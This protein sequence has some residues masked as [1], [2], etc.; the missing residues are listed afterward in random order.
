MST[1]IEKV[2]KQLSE[3][4]TIDLE[5]ENFICKDWRMY[6]NLFNP[7]NFEN[8]E[9]PPAWY[10]A[11]SVY[12]FDENPAS[13]ENIEIFSYE[14]IQNFQSLVTLIE[15]A[16][17]VENRLLSAIVHHTFGNGGAYAEAKFYQYA[18]RTIELLHHVDFTK[19][20][21]I[22][23]NL[24]LRTIEFG[25]EEFELILHFNCSWKAEH[26]LIIYLVNNEI[27]SIE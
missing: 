12:T 25:S 21:F 16:E 1:F 17:V 23:R 19:E 2:K 4:I 8:P 27:V 26:G 18:K 10:D 5:I 22:K 3:A 9:N 13:S 6:Y 14:K 11:S 7:E 24:R 20:E 15:N